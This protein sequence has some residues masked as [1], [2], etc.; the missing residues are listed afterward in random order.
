MKNI[1]LELIMQKFTSILATFR[2]NIFMVGFR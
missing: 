2:L 1:K